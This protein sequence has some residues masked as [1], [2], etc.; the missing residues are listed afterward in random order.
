MTSRYSRHRISSDDRWIWRH[1]HFL[2][3][4][5]KSRT[6]Y[7]SA[8]EHLPVGYK[9]TFPVKSLISLLRA[10]VEV[11]RYTIG[12][13]MHLRIWQAGRSV[14]RWR[15]EQKHGNGSLLR[16]FHTQ[17]QRC[18]VTACLSYWL[19]IGFTTLQLYN[20]TST[21]DTHYNASFKPYQGR[22]LLLTVLTVLTDWLPTGYLRPNQKRASGYSF[23]LM[24]LVSWSFRPEDTATL[25]CN[26]D[27]AKPLH[28][29]LPEKKPGVA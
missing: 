18:G 3:K 4:T 6:T 19:C 10:Q 22:Y 1:L 17:W 20:F 27:A 26:R 5:I 21:T 29:P 14:D 2:R 9:K 25:K 13:S 11:R 16:F 7:K 8:V 12:G 28:Y 23:A 24:F 15:R